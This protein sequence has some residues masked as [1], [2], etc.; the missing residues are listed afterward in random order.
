M[1]DSHHFFDEPVKNKI[2]IY[3]NIRKITTG[4]GMTIQLVA[5][6]IMHISKYAS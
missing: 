4:Q 3:D 2:R 1:I 6:L 5:C